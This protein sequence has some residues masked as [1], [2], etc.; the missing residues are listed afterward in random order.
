M[1]GRYQ[2][3]ENG[4]LA[5][6]I[7]VGVLLALVLVGGIYGL[8][9]YNA[10]KASEETT[11]SQDD[12]KAED[13]SKNSDQAAKKDDADTST[14][15]SSDKT[16]PDIPTDSDSS[17]SSTASN[18]GVESNALPQTGPSDVMTTMVTIALLTFA[19]AHFVQARRALS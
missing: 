6:F 18:Q 17:K 13:T 19:A 1:R 3:G 7:I 14:S 5:G 12:K 9:R 8:N 16:Q 4:S 11:A 10:Q 2:G 15:S